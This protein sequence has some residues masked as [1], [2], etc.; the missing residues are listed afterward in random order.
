MLTDTFV[1]QVKHKGAAIG[2]RY[3]DDGGPPTTGRSSWRSAR[4]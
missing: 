1:R 4:S 2:E 3:A